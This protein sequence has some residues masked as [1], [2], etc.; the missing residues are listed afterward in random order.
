M[1]AG[2]AG[3]GGLGRREK[4]AIVGLTLFGGAEDGV[5]LAY[6]DEAFRF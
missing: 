2:V 3:S 4:V 6:G 5:G 1:A